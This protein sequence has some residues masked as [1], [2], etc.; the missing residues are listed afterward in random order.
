[1]PISFFQ[2]VVIYTVK[3]FTA[4]SEEKVDVFLEFLLLSI[5]S[6]DVGYLT[7]SPSAFYK[8][9]IYIWKFL[10]HVLLKLSLIDFEH[11]LVSM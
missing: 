6:M 9:S 8:S 4:V 11:N 2:F 10:A 5:N 3:G 7:S 1:M